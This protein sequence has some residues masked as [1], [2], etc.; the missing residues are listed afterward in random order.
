[1]LKVL[2][3]TKETKIDVYLEI[4]GIFLIIGTF[5]ISSL[6]IRYKFRMESSEERK[7]SHVAKK[8]INAFEYGESQSFEFET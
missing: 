3:K 7:F 4:F 5:I 1:M 2:N 6:K 8:K